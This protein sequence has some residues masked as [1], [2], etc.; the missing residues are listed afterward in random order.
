M[1]LNMLSWRFS[2]EFTRTLKKSQQRRNPNTTEEAV[3]P[4]KSTEKK[5]HQHTIMQSLCLPSKVT[6]ALKRTVIKHAEWCTKADN[7]HFRFSFSDVFSLC[8]FLSLS[9]HK[10]WYMAVNTQPERMKRLGV[11]GRKSEQFNS[12]EVE[13]SCYLPVQLRPMYTYTEPWRPWATAKELADTFRA[14]R[15]HKKQ[16]ALARFTCVNTQVQV[17]V[18]LLGETAIEALRHIDV[19]LFR[20]PANRPQKS[21]KYARRNKHNNERKIHQEDAVRAH[22]AQGHFGHN[23]EEKV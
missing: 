23:S 13:R 4:D 19:L 8:V 1:A 14:L 16:R 2:A 11:T 9:G 22:L 18:Q 6:H 10:C 20:G 12:R 5:L 21:H 15:V 7:F 17:K 3:K